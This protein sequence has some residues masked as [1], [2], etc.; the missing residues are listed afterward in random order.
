MIIARLSHL[1]WSAVGKLVE[2]VVYPGPA[3]AYDAGPLSDYHVNDNVAARILASPWGGWVSDKVVADFYAGFAPW[4]V[5]NM[6]SMQPADL[7]RIAPV[8]SNVDVTLGILLAR[9]ADATEKLEQ[10]GPSNIVSVEDA[11]LKKSGDFVE[12]MREEEASRLVLVEYVER[13]ARDHGVAW[14]SRW[15]S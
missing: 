7:R 14:P 3:P 9:V 4:L 5:D 6:Y 8:A 2:L 1:F 10:A 12:A 13:S 11:L 15:Q